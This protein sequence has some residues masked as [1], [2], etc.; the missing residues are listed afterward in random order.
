MLRRLASLHDHVTKLG[1]SLGASAIVVLVLSYWYEITAR[2]FFAAPTTWASDVVSYL[3]SAS[4]FLIVPA[5]TKLNEHVSVPILIELLRPGAQRR[6]QKVLNIIS[7][8]VCLCTA[9][10]TGT[11]NFHQMVGGVTTMATH[12]IPKW[13]ITVFA[14]YGFLSSSMYFLRSA[15]EGPGKADRF[16]KE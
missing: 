8:V 12:P 3:L 5:V 6:V 9:F 2:Y 1:L 11:E 16:G 13:W 4:I 7:F 15:F 10:I 14:T